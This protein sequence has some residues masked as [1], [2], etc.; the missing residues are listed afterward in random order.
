MKMK[1]EARGGE[2][3]E[4]SSPKHNGDGFLA[5]A[6][7][8]QENRPL[9]RAIAEDEAHTGTVPQCR[10]RGISETV[11]ACFVPECFACKGSAR[12]DCLLPFTFLQSLSPFNLHQKSDPSCF[13]ANLVIFSKLRL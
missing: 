9:V 2:R 4:A 8:A 13:L 3:S 11:P 1:K 10:L 7:P 12:M 6:K 5:A